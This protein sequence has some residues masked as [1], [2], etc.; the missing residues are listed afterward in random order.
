MPPDRARQHQRCTDRLAGVLD[1]QPGDDAH[2]HQ[3]GGAR[4]REIDTE[5]RASAPCS[6]GT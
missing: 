6:V 2:Q 3:V 5:R 4:R 1:P